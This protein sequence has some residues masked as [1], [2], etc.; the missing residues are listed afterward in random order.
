M[1]NPIKEYKRLKRIVDYYE[2]NMLA[3]QR[4][5]RYAE[6]GLLLLSNVQP[7]D[8]IY[9][10]GAQLL[11]FQ[12]PLCCKVEKVEFIGNNDA[13]IHVKDILTGKKYMVRNRHHN[14]L[15]FTNKQQA[16]EELQRRRRR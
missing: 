12:K 15:F 5:R 1:K 14:I 4:C 3:M 9:L 16:Q 11:I 7:G 10:I 8:R 6:F 2:D 13:K